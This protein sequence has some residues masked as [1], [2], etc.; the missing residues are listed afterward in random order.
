MFGTGTFESGGSVAARGVAGPVEMDGVP[1]SFVPR[2]LDFE[3]ASMMEGP[4][5]ACFRGLRRF[6]VL[7]VLASSRASGSIFRRFGVGPSWSAP[8]KEPTSAV[9][10]SLVKASEGVGLSDPGVKNG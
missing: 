3:S 7:G 6:L 5:V 9:G 8:G 4:L 1:G 2:E 10:C